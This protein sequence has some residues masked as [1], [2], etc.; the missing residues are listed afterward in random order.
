[1]MSLVERLVARSPLAPAQTGLLL[2]WL[3]QTTTGGARLRAGVPP[4][5]SVADK[6]GTY[7]N[8]ANDVGLLYPP[9]GPPIAIA[10]YTFGQPSDAGGSAAIAECART[11]I[12]LLR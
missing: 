10:C 3:R 5:W 9:S 6:T 1:M 4:G 11:A 7:A 2:G 8:A 12:R